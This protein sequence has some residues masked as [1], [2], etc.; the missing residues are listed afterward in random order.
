MNIYY[1]GQVAG[2][3][4]FQLYY[5]LCLDLLTGIQSVRPQNSLRSRGIAGDMNL[6][7]FP[8]PIRLFNIKIIPS[9]KMAAFN[10]LE[11]SVHNTLATQKYLNTDYMISQ[12][13]QSHN[14]NYSSISFKS[15]IIFMS[16]VKCYNP[17]LQG[18]IIVED[19]FLVEDLLKRQGICKK[20]IMGPHLMTIKMLIYWTFPPLQTT[21]YEFV[22][23]SKE[24]WE[25]NSITSLAH[26]WILCSEWVPSEWESKQLIKTSKQ[27]TPLQ[28]TNIL[29]RE[30]LRVCMKQ[31]YHW[32]M[33]T[34]NHRFWL[35][36]TFHNPL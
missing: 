18:E 14:S 36:K 7:A 25:K 6:A 26:Q 27:P 8:D 11:G 2:L 32:G 4:C 35:K 28:Y 29:W 5:N 24:I 33:L 15:V 12:H 20:K 1:N 10:L 3:I 23:S 21:Q 17:S 16:C 22:S 31:I 13:S 19:S 9:N 34:L 30:K